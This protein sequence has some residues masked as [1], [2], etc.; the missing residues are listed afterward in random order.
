MAAV[1]A[2]T[3]QLTATVTNT[4]LVPLNTTTLVFP[5]G[6]VS[7]CTPPLGL[8]TGLAAGAVSVCTLQYTV[9]QADIDAGTYSNTPI[10]LRANVTSGS[11][12]GVP[13]GGTFL[14]TVQAQGSKVI[15][16][17]KTVLNTSYAEPGKASIE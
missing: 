12:W 16:F 15:V 6:D 7:S 14:T 5:Q 8:P 4:G 3:I 10:S 13:I 1:H 2:G 9:T 11:Y 17:D